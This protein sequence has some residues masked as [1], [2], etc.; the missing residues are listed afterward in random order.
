MG[1]LLSNNHQTHNG[2]NQTM[3]AMQ[4]FTEFMEEHRQFSFEEKKVA[5][6]EMSDI[7]DHDNSEREESDT[8]NIQRIVDNVE[9]SD[10]AN[11]AMPGFPIHGISIPYNVDDDDSDT[12]EP[13][14][15]PQTLEYGHC[16]Y[17]DI[18]IQSDPEN[19]SDE[20]LLPSS[21]PE[22]SISLNTK[23]W[24]EIKTQRMRRK[25]MTKLSDY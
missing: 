20:D 25:T 18:K 1:N 7:S 23:T 14:D 21:F 11:I 9:N 3:Q 22:L 13:L 19:D 17:N 2:H 12:P 6:L 4:A 8:P 10:H 15:T 5:S 24:K 16:D